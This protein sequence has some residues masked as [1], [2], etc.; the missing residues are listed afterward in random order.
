MK[1]RDYRFDNAKAIL[2]FLV[3]LS[4]SIGT[5]YANRFQSYGIDHLNYAIFSFHMPCFAF[6]SGYFSHKVDFR[7][8][9]ANILI[10]YL[11]VDFFYDVL[12]GI[13]SSV[14]LSIN[15]FLPQWTL[16]YLL[17][18]FFWKV[19]VDWVQ[20]FRFPIL[21]S[22]ILSL[23]IGTIDDAGS[24]L[25]ISRTICMFPYFIIGYKL[26]EHN[27]DFERFISKKKNKS[28][29]LVLF[30]VAQILVFVMANNGVDILT[31]NLKCSY[32]VLGQS[33][34]EGIL[35]RFVTHI[36]GC[37]GIVFI[38]MIAPVKNIVITNIG[39]YSMTVYLAHSFI[40]K[41]SGKIVNFENPFLTIIMSFVFSM[42]ICF[43]FGNSFV[44]SMYKK[45][46]SLANSLILHK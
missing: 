42:V 3:V 34:K 11:L 45:V 32:S 25:S 9:V 31:F 21:N 27:S 20:H 10:P 18:L 41:I 29:I 30:I 19:S 36:V 17:S 44:N 37:I 38:L 43:L 28:I 6:I 24:F 40:L 1:T 4:H 13:F 23:L 16:W 39:T 15:P 46:L 8:C 5:F 35:L 14:P 26:N 22:I 7:K 33:L 2:I 12:F